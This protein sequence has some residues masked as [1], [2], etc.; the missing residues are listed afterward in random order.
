LFVYKKA[1]SFVAPSF[2]AALANPS[3]ID[4]PFKITSPLGVMIGGGRITSPP[5]AAA[6]AYA[7]TKSSW[8][9][10]STADDSKGKALFGSD[11]VSPEVLGTGWDER[12]K[13]ILLDIRIIVSL[14]KPKSQPISAIKSSEHL[15]I[16]V[17]FEEN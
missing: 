1:N 4:V 16:K 10:R 5:I 14:P 15:W 12:G 11:N 3:A 17:S 6:R 9:S 8:P 2:S 13:E 7:P